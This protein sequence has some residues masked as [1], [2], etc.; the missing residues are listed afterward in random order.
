MCR[1]KNTIQT[2]I[3]KKT[4]IFAHYLT[5]VGNLKLM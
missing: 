1:N 5:E 2:M 3:Q 4:I